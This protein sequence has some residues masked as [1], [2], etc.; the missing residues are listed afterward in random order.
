MV[1]SFALCKAAATTQEVSM[2]LMLAAA[3]HHHR[4][5]AGALHTTCL[6]VTCQAAR[7]CLY[8]DS[9][10]Q[11]WSADLGNASQQLRMV[12]LPVR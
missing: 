1:C 9:Q 6:V 12:G 10:R 2:A 7:G 3:V 11:F 8:G 5:T 4:T